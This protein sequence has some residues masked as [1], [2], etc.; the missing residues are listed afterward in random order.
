MPYHY[1]LLLLL[2]FTTPAASQNFE[3]GLRLG[4]LQALQDNIPNPYGRGIHAPIA[5]WQPS[6]NL[7]VRYRKQR[8][9]AAAFLEKQ[10]VHFNMVGQKWIRGSFDFNNDRTYVAFGLEVGRI[11]RLAPRWVLLPTFGVSVTAERSIVGYYERVVR[12]GGTTDRLG[13]FKKDRDFTLD[14]GVEIQYE[15]PRRLVFHLRTRF[16]RGTSHLFPNMHRYS[17]LIQPLLRSRRRT[18]LERQ[19]GMGYRLGE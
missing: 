14:G 5:S 10:R 9:T 1:L 16:Q 15:L 12:L 13:P 18:T 11:V 3:I 4:R 2:A 8:W 7:Y 19:V 6:Q 17:E